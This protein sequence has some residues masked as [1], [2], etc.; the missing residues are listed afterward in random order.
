MA[1]SRG[2]WFS[3]LAAHYSNPKVSIRS[4]GL[5]MTGNIYPFGFVRSRSS[6]G[7][8]SGDTQMRPGARFSFGGFITVRFQ[9]PAVVQQWENDR[10]DR[11]EDTL[12]CLPFLSNLKPKAD[13]DEHLGYADDIY[14]LLR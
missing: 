1:I 7:R 12:N 13:S 4:G 5:Q 3:S 10:P 9:G 2:L 8:N 11:T 14:L 6:I